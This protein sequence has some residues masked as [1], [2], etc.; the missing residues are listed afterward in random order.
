LDYNGL[1]GALPEAWGAQ[2]TFRSLRSLLL[3]GNMLSGEL[4]ASWGLPGRFLDLRCGVVER[5][6]GLRW[7]LGEI[8]VS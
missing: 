5:M 4:P 7:H 1:S 8:G 3:Q 2:G 6:P